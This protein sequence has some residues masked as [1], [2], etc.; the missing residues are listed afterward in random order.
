MMKLNFYRFVFL[1]IFSFVIVGSYN[2]SFAD[3]IKINKEHS[4]IN[5]VVL[6]DF[7]PFFQID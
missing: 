5:I 6:K 3:E 4:S 7:P 1:L 2:L